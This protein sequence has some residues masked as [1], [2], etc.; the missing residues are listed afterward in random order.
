[1]S[2]HK[3]LYCQDDSVDGSDPSGHAVY[4]VTR[5][6]QGGGGTWAQYQMGFGHGYLLITSEQDL[7][8]SKHPLKYWPALKTFSY[9]PAD[10]TYMDGHGFDTR[11]V[12]Q[13]RIWERDS[14]DTQP[15]SYDAYLVTTDS[16]L[17]KKLIAAIYA[18]RDTWQVGYDFGA[19]SPQGDPNHPGNAIGVPSRHKEPGDNCAYYSVNGQNCVWWSTIMLMQNGFTPLPK[20]VATAI[21]NFNGSIGFAQDVINDPAGNLNRVGLYKNNLFVMR[22]LPGYCLDSFGAF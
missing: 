22:S 1:L 12:T 9:H 8:K 20:N 3:Y 4:F 6:F 18:W 17:Q 11:L 14:H 2:L 21:S 16:D 13:G 15:S 7:G 19:P 10:F 5:K